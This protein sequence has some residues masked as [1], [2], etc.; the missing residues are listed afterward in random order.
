[1]FEFE[2]I[3]NV[4]DTDGQAFRGKW[5]RVRITAGI[6]SFFFIFVEY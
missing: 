6:Y 1:M 4:A 2:L 3:G 5:V